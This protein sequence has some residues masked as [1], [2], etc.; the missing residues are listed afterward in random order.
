MANF[1][2]NPHVIRQLGKELVSDSITALMELVKNSYDADASY[3]K[4]CIN[5]EDV[6][7]DASLTYPNHKGYITVEDNGIGMDEDTILKSWL[8]ISYSNKR[9]DENGVKTKTGKD[10]TPLG[11]KGLGRLSTQKLADICEIYSKVQHKDGVHVAFDWR[12]FDEVEKLSEV[13]VEFCKTDWIG[14]QGT[15]LVLAN[16]QDSA[17]WRGANLDRFK[18]LLCKLISPY[19]TKQAFSVYLNI[20]GEDID[21]IQESQKVEKLSVSDIDFAYSDDKITVNVDINVR[22]LI[23]NKYPEYCKFVLPDNGKRFLDIFL[24]QKKA[25]AFSKGENGSWL[26]YKQEIY[27]SDIRDLSFVDGLIADPGPFSGKIWEYNYN[28]LGNEG[29]SDIY[30]SFDAYKSY[31][32]S[33]IGIRLYRNGF[34]VR[35]YGVTEDDWLSLSKGQTS[36]SSYYGLRPSNV[37]G[38]IQIDEGLNNH[39][40]DKTDREG[41][42][43]N[44]YQRNFILICKEVISRVNECFELLRR[45]YNDFLDGLSKNNTKIKNLTDAYN[46]ISDTGKTSKEVSEE[47]D[48]VVKAFTYAQHKL[49][50]ITQQDA[51]LFTNASDPL[52]GETLNE[53]RDLLNRSSDVLSRTC[54]L[55]KKSQNLDETILL[56]KPKID[57]L[58]DQ[59]KSFSELASLGLVSEMVSHDLGQITDRLLGKSRDLESLTKKGSNISSEVIYDLISF[60]KSTVASIRS[61]IKHLDSSMKYS[62]DKVEN[63]WVGEMLKNEEGHFYEQK[64]KN[65]GIAFK[66]DCINDFAVLMNP[67]KFIQVFDNL[68]NNSIYWLSNSQEKEIRIIVDKPWVY[69]ED[70]GPGIDPSVED[71]L[72]EAFVTRKP[73]D[74]GRGLGLFIVR[75]LLDDYGCQIVLGDK[76]NSAGRVCQFA[77]IFTPLIN[78]EYGRD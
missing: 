45:S 13:E 47:Y 71:T 8:I 35:P 55:L 21:L 42:I 63:F 64:F 69:V 67:G 4:I 34:A 2:I 9:A 19:E 60:I 3:V 40:K 43:D 20:N 32:Q 50:A 77:L 37:I 56:L 27:I 28:K 17:V 5:T 31:V 76:R 58:E 25:S 26:N 18:G 38:Y 53:V 78:E 49:D 7:N 70:S 23:G 75:Q 36:G 16:L 6:Y 11:D 41:L 33:Q 29:W 22:K 62:R 66:V 74:Q 46:L 10:R 1:D 59:L 68:I 51:S 14:S 44:E 48:S 52:I 24:G 72:F 54:E 15:R 30:A 39:L 57:A 61:Q 73:Y 12:K 65:L